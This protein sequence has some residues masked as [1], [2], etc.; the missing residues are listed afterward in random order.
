MIVGGSIDTSGGTVVVVLEAGTVELVVVLVV[1]SEVVSFGI[2]TDTGG[3]EVVELT[4]TGGSQF[5]FSGCL[6]HFHAPAEPMLN[7]TAPRA[8]TATRVK[9]VNARRI[10][11]S[12]VR[13]APS[14]AD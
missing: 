5:G 2:V 3:C 8:V 1:G 9:A 14:D 13:A 12:A 11:P 7:T 6:S 10:S 4:V